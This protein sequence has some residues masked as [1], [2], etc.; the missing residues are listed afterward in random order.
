MDLD[1]VNIAGVCSGLGWIEFAAR[2]V[3]RRR[4]YRSRV[5]CHCEREAVTAALLGRLSAA[6]GDSAPVW[7]DISTF[8]GRA[9]RGVVDCL[10]AGLPCPAYSCAGSRR[11]NADERAWGPDGESGPQ[12]HFL[13]IAGEMLPGIIFLENVP[14]W[15]SGGHFRRL[16][17]GLLGLGYRIAP[18][19]FLSAEDV[20]G[21]QRR[22]RV[23]V[24]AF[25]EGERAGEPD[26]DGLR[27]RSGGN[28]WDETIKRGGELGS[29]EERGQRGDGCASGDSG[30]V[31][32]PGGELG[33]PER[34]ERGEGSAGWGS[35]R[36]VVAGRAGEAVGLCYSGGFGAERQCEAARAALLREGLGMFPPERGYWTDPEWQ[37]VLAV[38]A[39]YAPA[40]EPGFSVVVDGLAVS[41]ADLL[42]IGG[43]GVVPLAAA[44]ALD[45]LLDYAGV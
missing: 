23:Y 34:V 10:V 2:E 19:L 25:R 6:T 43:N 31:G 4:G 15:V 13:R 21:S 22:E 45:V 39:S 38:D 1:A 36:G 24:L 12:Y 3:F 8:D 14:Q 41:G 44:V 11:G 32:E 27:E 37:W 35:G 9:W 26:Y 29:G 40:A 16:G 17:E 42:R 30:H 7:D 33:V 28:A 20:G 18:A 5:V